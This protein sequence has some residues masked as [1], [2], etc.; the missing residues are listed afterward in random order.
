MY[1]Y[2]YPKIVCYRKENAGYSAGDPVSNHTAN[3]AGYPP[4]R[5]AGYPADRISEN[6]VW[7]DT[8][9][10][11]GHVRYRYDKFTATCHSKKFKLNL[12][13]GLFRTFL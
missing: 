8:N 11:P 1:R 2:F 9:P 7:R 4:F 3:S 10:D 6:S 5:L 12:K 13:F